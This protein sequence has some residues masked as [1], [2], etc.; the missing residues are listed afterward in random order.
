[1][2]TLL[3]HDRKFVSLVLVAFFLKSTTEEQ[4]QWSIIS[5]FQEKI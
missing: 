2:E 1:M 4:A 3:E 5:G